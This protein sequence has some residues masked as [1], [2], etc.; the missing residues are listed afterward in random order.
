LAGSPEQYSPVIE[1]FREVAQAAIDDG[2][3]ILVPGCGMLS[4]MLTI[5]GITEVDGVPIFDPMVVGIKIAEAMV[6]MFKAGLPVISRKGHYRQ[7]PTS[8][9]EQALA[10]LR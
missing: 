1:D 7:A 2:A 6:D 10:G 9:V 4:P 5:N 8:M 3:E